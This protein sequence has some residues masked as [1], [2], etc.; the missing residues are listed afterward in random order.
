MP[1]TLSPQ[2]RLVALI[3]LLATAALVVSTQLVFR[4][5]LFS[6][7]SEPTAV[8]ASVSAGTK[9]TEAP[10]KAEAEKSAPATDAAKADA[11]NASTPSKGSTATKADTANATAATTANPATQSSPRTHGLPLPVAQ[12]LQRHRVVVVSVFSPKGAVDG[13]AKA[14]AEAGA[15]AAGA[16]FVALSALERDNAEPLAT[17]L[18]VL[19]APSVLVYTRPAKLFVKLDGFADL[20]TV[21]QAAANARA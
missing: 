1:T 21:A 12:A 17:K 5:V 4:G 19:K 10:A 9:K 3:G 20:A 18:G 14:E 8:P 6:G 11:K 13:L 7:D 2:I 15:E 16:G